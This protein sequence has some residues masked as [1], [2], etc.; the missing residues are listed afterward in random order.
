MN[1]SATVMRPQRLTAQEIARL[2][3]YVLMAV[4]G[5]RVIHPGGR[6]STEELFRLGDFQAN[7][8]ILDIGCGVATTAI[9]VARRFG[10]AVTAVDVSPIMLERARHAVR[11]AGLTGS[12]T[13]EEGD[14]LALRF[15]DA[16]F[17]RVIAE[18]VTMFVERP[19]A[20]RE[21]VRVCRPGGRVLATE[22][23]WHR[24][25]TPAAREIFLGQ[26][27]PGMQVDVQ[28]DWVRL[29]QE[30]SLEEIQVTSGPFEMMTPAGFLSDEGV[31]GSMAFMGRALTRWVYVKKLAWL[32]P[33]MQRAVPYL[34]YLVVA[35]TKERT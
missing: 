34:G 8:S 5:K 23:F 29:Y 31:P 28:D 25:P 26:V 16:S 18:A 35:G 15:P 19:K 9:Q 6:R 20:A 2:D 27:C 11:A 12:V 32:M 22:F 30:A 4:I 13:V 1:L 7:L 24:P 33:Q 14:I 21:L 10:G 3:P 17:E